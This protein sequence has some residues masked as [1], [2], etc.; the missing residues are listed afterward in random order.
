MQESQK[1]SQGLI[2][3]RHIVHST[4]LRHYQL[5]VKDRYEN[6]KI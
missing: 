1:D 6:I 5:P 4:T 2:K 3:L